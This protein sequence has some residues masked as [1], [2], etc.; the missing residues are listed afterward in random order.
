MKR[1]QRWASTPT[2]SSTAEG[3]PAPPPDPLVP[4]DRPEAPDEFTS[5]RTAENH[6]V[7]AAALESPAR[8]HH[9]LAFTANA[10]SHKVNA[11]S[12]ITPGSRLKG[13]I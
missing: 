12:P 10:R 6:V 13:A 7:I 4:H 8:S 11:P 9:R 1:R 2:S 3:G 5:D